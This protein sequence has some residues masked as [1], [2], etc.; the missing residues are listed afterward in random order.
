VLRALLDADGLRIEHR[1]LFCRA[2]TLYE[3]GSAD[4]ADGLIGLRHLG[5]GA[6]HTMTFGHKAAK[7]PGF[8]LFAPEIPSE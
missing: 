7:L 5:A 3:D 4:F 1:D 6:T 8:K 2:V